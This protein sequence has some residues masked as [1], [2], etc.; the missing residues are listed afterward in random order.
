MKLTNT[1]GLM[2]HFRLRPVIFWDSTIMLR[3][4]HGRIRFYDQNELLQDPSKI[5]DVP[6]K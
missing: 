4:A 5:N 2:E 1:A 6:I 3:S